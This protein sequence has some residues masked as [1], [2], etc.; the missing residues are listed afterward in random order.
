MASLSILVFTVFA[1]TVRILAVIIG[2]LG[3]GSPLKSSQG[4]VSQS[5]LQNLYQISAVQMTLKGFASFTR[6]RLTL[7]TLKAI[8]EVPSISKCRHNVVI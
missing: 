8:A 5:I 1:S 4:H 2:S 7:L 6:L 3:L